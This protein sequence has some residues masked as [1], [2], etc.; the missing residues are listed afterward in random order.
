MNT[1]FST[2]AL[3]LCLPLMS[4]ASE[5]QHYK[6]G[7]CI[8]ATD[9]DYSWFGKVAKVEAYSEIDGMPSGK[10]YILAFPTY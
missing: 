8:I 7:D 4:H 5:K 9:P 1:R 10:H 2:V 6:L 3:L